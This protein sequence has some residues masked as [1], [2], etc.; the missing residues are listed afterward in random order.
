VPSVCGRLARTIRMLASWSY[1]RGWVSV[2]LDVSVL[3]DGGEG[4][5]YLLS[6]FRWCYV[7]ILRGVSA[8][9]LDRGLMKKV[10]E[11]AELLLVNYM[12]RKRR[13]M[14]GR[15]DGR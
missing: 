12:C 8:S 1:F 9:K 2:L 6:Y 3:I 15:V 10:E 4:K 7:S 5:A 11:D 13:A 14:N